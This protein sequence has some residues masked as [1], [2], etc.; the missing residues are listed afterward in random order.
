MLRLKNNHGMNY[1][2]NLVFVIESFRKTGLDATLR[3]IMSAFDKQGFNCQSLRDRLIGRSSKCVYRVGSIQDRYGSKLFV[4][5]K[6]GNFRFNDDILSHECAAAEFLYKIGHPLPSFTILAEHNGR[7]GLVTEDL[8]QGGVY[9]VQHKN[10]TNQYIQK[11]E[12]NQAYFSY[13]QTGVIP[14]ELSKK[15]IILQ[16]FLRR[17]RGIRV[18]KKT[19]EEKTVFFDNEGLG[20]ECYGLQNTEK[21]KRELKL[22]LN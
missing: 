4:A 5:L 21:Y 16:D 8:T 22:F 14:P 18:N 19:L 13:L 10:S 11:E 20:S 15:Y 6:I 3:D 17:Q 9:D 1:V 7:F 12:I 2:K